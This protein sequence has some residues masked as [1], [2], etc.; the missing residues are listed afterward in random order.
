MDNYK[1]SAG[2]LD[3]VPEITDKRGNSLFHLI[4]SLDRMPPHLS[5]GVD[6]LKKYNVDPTTQNKDGQTPLMMLHRRR[7]DRYRLI[8]EVV[9]SVLSHF[10]KKKTKKKKSKRNK[11]SL[12]PDSYD[13]HR[14]SVRG[15]VN[16]D[17]RKQKYDE[18]AKI[19][20]SNEMDI[21]RGRIA[22][23][24]R[25]LEIKIEHEIQEK[26]KTETNP[27]KSFSNEQDGNEHPIHD[28]PGTRSLSRAHEDRK[29]APSADVNVNLLDDRE[30][31]ED[32][33][34]SLD[35]LT[36]EVECTAQ[37][38]KILQ[39]KRLAPDMKKRMVKII[40]ELASGNMEGHLAKRLEGL[41][42]QNNILLYESKL[43]K[44]ARILWER[45]VAFSPRCSNNSEL[46]GEMKEERHGRIYSEVIRIW[47]IVLDHDTVPRKIKSIVHSHKRG[48]SCVIK[49]QLK[50]FKVGSSSP[51]QKKDGLC[52]P[53]FYTHKDDLERQDR[54]ED[55]P[56]NIDSK[57]PDEVSS[58][59]IPPGSPEETEYHILK[60]YAFSNSLVNAVLEDC[61]NIKIDFPFRVSELEHAVI[62]LKPN[63]MSS[64]LLLGRSG[65]GKTTCCLYRLWSNY[66]SYWQRHTIDDPGFIKSAQFIPKETD[67][68][69]LKDDEVSCGE[70]DEHYKTEAAKEYGG[71]SSLQF[72]HLIDL[73][74]SNTAT[75]NQEDVV[76]SNQTRNDVNLETANK[77]PDYEHLHQAFITKNSVLCTEVQKNFLDL[78]QACPATRSNCEYKEPSSVNKLD[79]LEE[80]A[81]PLFLCSRDWLLMLDASLPEPA[82]FPR[83]DEGELLLSVKGWGEEDNHLQV[84]PDVV[85]EDDD[86]QE[87]EVEL[88]PDKHEQ[89]GQNN[90]KVMSGVDPRL[91]VTYQ[92]F[93]NKLWPKMTKKRKVHYHPSLVWTEICSFIKGSVE[94]LHSGDGYI[95]LE[96]Y[97]TLGRKRAPSFSADRVIVYE[98]FQAYQ[99]IKRREGM[100]DEADLVYHIYCRLQGIVPEWSIH[101]I[102]VDETQDFTQA[103]LSVIIRCCRDPNRLFFT[104]DTAQSIMRGVAF[105][106]NDL[107]SLFYY[108]KQS[109]EAVGQQAQVHVPDRVYQLTHNYRSHT[110]IL[111]LA[112]SVTD[113]LLHF[114]P[115]SFDRMER[116]QGLFHGPKPVVLESCSFSDLAVILRGYKRKTSPIEFGAHQVVLVASDEARDSLPE[117]L[118]LALVMTIYE[119]KGLEFDDVL[120]YNFFKESQVREH[121]LNLKEANLSIIPFFCTIADLY[122]F[123]K[124]SLSSSLC[125]SLRKWEKCKPEQFHIFFSFSDSGDK[126]LT[127]CAVF[128]NC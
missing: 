40:I 87:N 50:G 86:D 21:V 27:S 7:D 16:A 124:D 9:N 117:E 107:R 13:V 84:I 103:E 25:E 83:N 67:S 79:Q 128:E 38:W 81:W 63:P 22:D 33:C 52:L 57:R 54:G 55:L 47:D 119:A 45:A 23:A 96:E 101:E 76:L 125:L 20:P 39:G 71:I 98:L 17:E 90:P 80:H 58:M 85:S 91:E 24:I 88:H 68:N 30:E 111:N 34:A 35:N 99:R 72:Q 118:S 18:V 5:K 115:E 108:M 127:S 77:E 62:N 66:Q 93:K 116:D 60:F 4:A 8:E 15:D 32:F 104:G 2:N 6:L 112:S 19:H 44:A 43:S 1:Q 28:R 73:T 36:W 65:T 29:P 46:L 3:K 69:I 123:L 94:A 48:S 11:D 14:S 78:R 95:N 110:G 75:V 82:F 121:I 122:S 92:V 49:K 56:R 12:E 97:Q 10:P 106:F 102:Y 114:F 37:V 53:N 51:N 74:G 59:F 105:R 42:K 26:S 100:F 126:L 109:Y 61:D 41:P 64:V 120:L 70:D 113:L 31:F 89:D